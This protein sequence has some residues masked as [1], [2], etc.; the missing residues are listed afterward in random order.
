MKPVGDLVLPCIT[1]RMLVLLYTGF[2]VVEAGKGELSSE[3]TVVGGKWNAEC[4][5]GL[6]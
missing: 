1:F 2:F 5:K 4:N 6:T 3:Y